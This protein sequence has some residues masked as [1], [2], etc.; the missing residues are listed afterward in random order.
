MISSLEEKRRGTCQDLAKSNSKYCSWS[1]AWRLYSLKLPRGFSARKANVE[2]GDAGFL[3]NF[4]GI[5]TRKSNLESVNIG[6][7]SLPKLV[8]HLRS[9]SY[10]C[11]SCISNL[12]G[13]PCLRCLPVLIRGL[14]SIRNYAASKYV[15]PIVEVDLRVC[16]ILI[17]LFTTT[18]AS[19]LPARS[20]NETSRFDNVFLEV[21]LRLTGPVQLYSDQ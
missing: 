1:R 12:P 19:S 7:D 9:G 11:F 8:R 6:P 4:G 20:P 16:S 10:L 3:H 21:Y 18:S 13:S 15:D 5:M 17:L 2:F 14:V